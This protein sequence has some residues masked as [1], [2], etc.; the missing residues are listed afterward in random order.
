MRRTL[1][2]A[3]AVVLL[4][5][6]CR[7]EAN[8]L[9]NVSDDGSGTVTAEVG[10]DDELQEL[11]G[12]FGGGTEDLFNLVPEG[13]D[14]VTRRDGDMTFY[15]AE[16]SFTD[17]ADLQQ[18]AGVFADADVVFSELD[19]VVEDGGA[20]LNAVIDAPDSGETLEGLGAGGLQDIGQDIFSSSLIVD[21]PG[22]VEDSNADETLSDG[23]LKWDIPLLGGTVDIQ[24]TTSGGGGGISLTLI[25]GLVAAVLVIAAAFVWTQRQRKG[26]VDALESVAQ[27][28][29]P[30]GIFDDRP[31]SDDTT[32]ERSPNQ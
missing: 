25:L 18:Q 22:T 28:A 7:A 6:A 27:P 2:L 10:I 20:R 9:L 21:L 24:A 12:Q 23:R 14:V 5:T 31:G 3:V 15:S 29:A 19:L 32:G 4:T 30:S 11:I 1:L 13:Q 26:S 17:T 16:Q 8:F